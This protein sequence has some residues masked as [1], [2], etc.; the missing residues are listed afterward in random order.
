[1]RPTLYKP[2]GYVKTLSRC[3]VFLLCVLSLTSYAGII[4][5]EN[6]TKTEQQF[7]DYTIY[8]SSFNSTF[9]TPEISGIYSLKRDKKTGLISIV[10]TYKGELVKANLEGQTSNL[11]S[12]NEKLNF[13]VIEEGG[14]IYYMAPFNFIND[15]LL[16]FQITVTHKKTQNPISIKF[17]K[18]FYE[19]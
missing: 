8:F 12:Q 15:E 18:K 3:T 4:N 2:Y 6:A 9:I 1:M 17:S 16:R 10:V 11:M 13:K 19:G 7:G 14:S 5:I